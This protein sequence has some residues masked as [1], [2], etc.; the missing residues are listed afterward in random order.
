[1]DCLFLFFNLISCGF[2]ILLNLCWRFG[3]YEMGSAW[4]VLNM[5]ILRASPALHS[6]V[7]EVSY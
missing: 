2:V 6:L 7:M 4:N 1:M 3:E 5:H